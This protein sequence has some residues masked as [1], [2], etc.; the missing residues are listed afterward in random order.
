MTLTGE[1]YL[2][3][4]RSTMGLL[5]RQLPLL[6]ITNLICNFLVLWGLII[7]VGIPCIVSYLLICGVT[8][9]DQDNQRLAIVGIVALCSTLISTVIFEILVESVCCIFIYYAI[10]KSFMDR[11]LI[12]ANRIQQNTTETINRCSTNPYLMDGGSQEQGFNN[13][14][15]RM[16]N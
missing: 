10:D 7:S 1:S 9:S 4:A 12:T 3:G 14:Y 2:E 11:G 15:N 8:T 16:K 6:S 5:W 13:D